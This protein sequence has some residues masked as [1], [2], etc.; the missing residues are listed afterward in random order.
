MCVCVYVCVCLKGD[1]PRTEPILFSAGQIGFVHVISFIFERLVVEAARTA[2]QRLVR[3]TRRA[4]AL[5]G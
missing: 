3:E 1:A 4:A 2:G 5:C